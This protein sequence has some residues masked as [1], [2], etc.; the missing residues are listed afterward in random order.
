MENLAILVGLPDWTDENVTITLEL[1]LLSCS[2]PGRY[3]EPKPFVCTK[4]T[5]SET[6]FTGSLKLRNRSNVLSIMSMPL[7]LVD[8]KEAVN[9][10]GVEHETILKTSNDVPYTRNGKYSGF[11]DVQVSVIFTRLRNVDVSSDANS[12]SNESL[13]YKETSPMAVSVREKTRGEL[14]DHTPNYQAANDVESQSIHDIH[15]EE[16]GNDPMHL[17]MRGSG[18]VLASTPDYDN[19]SLCNMSTQISSPWDD[20]KFDNFYV[21]PW[22]HCSVQTQY[23]L[24][25]ED[26]ES[27]AASNHCHLFTNCSCRDKNGT[28]T[29][30]C[31]KCI[32]NHMSTQHSCND[33]EAGP[34]VPCCK[35]GITAEVSTQYSRSRLMQDKE[36]D[37]QDSFHNMRLPL[38][39]RKSSVSLSSLSY[40]LGDLN[41]Q[42]NILCEP[43][44]SNLSSDVSAWP[45]SSTTT[46]IGDS[47]TLP[48]LVSDE[49]VS[50]HEKQL[51]QG[52]SVRNL[53]NTLEQK[54]GAPLTRICKISIPNVPRE[55]PPFPSTI[56]NFEGKPKSLLNKELCLTN[57]IANVNPLG[58]FARCEVVSNIEVHVAKDPF[59][60]SEQKYQSYYED[61]DRY[62]E[63]HRENVT[64]YFDDARSPTQ[65]AE[66]HL[67]GDSSRSGCDTKMEDFKVC[68]T[69]MGDILATTSNSKD[70]EKSSDAQ[71]SKERLETYEK[72]ENGIQ[73]II[74]ELLK[75][76]GDIK[77]SALLHGA[78]E[79]SDP[80]V[81]LDYSKTKP[82]YEKLCSVM[83]DEMGKYSTTV[84]EDTSV[85]IGEVLDEII[86]KSSEIANS[87]IKD[88]ADLE[89]ETKAS[90]LGLTYF[91]NS[92]FTDSKVPKTSYSFG[93]LACD[94]CITIASTSSAHLKQ[95]ANDSTGEQAKI[96]CFLAEDV[97]C[98]ETVERAQSEEEIFQASVSLNSITNMTAEFENPKELP[99]DD[100]VMC[101]ETDEEAFIQNIDLIKSDFPLLPTQTECN[102]LSEQEI[103]S[104]VPDL[105][106]ST[107]SSKE[108]PSAS[109]VCVALQQTPAIHNIQ[110]AITGKLD[111]SSGNLMKVK[112]LEDSGN[113][114]SDADDE[115]ENISP[116]LNLPKSM[117]KSKQDLNT[118]Q[119]IEEIE[120]NLQDNDTCVRKGEVL[121][122]SQKSPN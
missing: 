2:T 95:I 110:R 43:K 69:K 64:R 51:S 45:T 98:H 70:I 21:Q 20:T 53:E 39:G 87:H 57:K 55:Y 29:S 3:Q 7:Y 15:L 40:V 4:E 120:K 76:S 71:L 109:P 117:Y 16:S 60:H 73:N 13:K 56:S 79:E 25:Y 93:V 54:S 104:T 5:D 37:V 89:N 31:Q 77:E 101:K 12:A 44:D 48:S 23:L 6:M 97:Q 32:V 113:E 92:T 107:S 118:P 26:T 24:T 28:S 11:E 61:N 100:K 65:Q 112:I 22:G 49:S 67:G 59:R 38:T 86:D 81:V 103:F 83:M 35:I 122:D 42:K 46:N 41:R 78:K 36:V 52:F 74:K 91:P 106:P 105:Q 1:N 68:L 30:Q 34:S 84:N 102:S 58:E 111:N 19:L 108:Q 88:R 94:T 63:T 116:N 66:V 75:E 72:A 96:E 62:Y 99:T 27:A 9:S 115:T 82:D 18:V 17:R 8:S 33:E 114:S 85:M 90:P 80:P 47:S 119:E 10:Q 50:L 14:V 121:F